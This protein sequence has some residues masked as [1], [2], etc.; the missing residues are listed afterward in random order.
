MPSAQIAN[1]IL[2]SKQN[3]SNI[4]RRETKIQIMRFKTLF[5]MAI[6]ALLIQACAGNRY[7]SPQFDEKTRQHTLIAVMPV[8]MIFTGNLPKNLTPEQ[9][10]EIEVAE[11]KAF[12][13]S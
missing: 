13:L 11:S 10:A 12:Q 1:F 7:L 5:L 3:W 4:C 8:E 9:I 2:T 6:T